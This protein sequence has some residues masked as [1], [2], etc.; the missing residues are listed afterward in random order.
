MKFKYIL[1]L[2]LIL[3]CAATAQITQS[4]NSGLSTISQ[5]DLMKTVEY[6]SSKDL[7]GRL[8]GSEGYNKAACYMADEFQKL[9]LKP[10]GDSAYFQKLKVEYNEIYPPVKIGLMEDG[11]RLPTGLT[12]RRVVDD[13]SRRL[14]KEY[15]LGKDF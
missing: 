8:S 15:K 5:N 2:Y 1:P 3:V 9:G 14:K 11:R 12:T 4:V 7:A 13:S 10:L 6:L